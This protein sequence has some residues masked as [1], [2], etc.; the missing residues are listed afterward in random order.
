V[1]T[2]TADPNAA[3]NT[4]SAFTAVINPVP[5]ISGA[6]VDKSTLWP[7]NH[8]MVDVEVMYAVTGA[9]ATATTTLSIAS[10]EGDDADYQVVDAHHVRVRAERAGGDNDR[11][12]TI[13][14]AATSD[15]KTFTRRTVTVT[16]PH[17]QGKGK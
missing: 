15:K 17:D 4:A 13:T 14:I 1:Q 7:P 11:V 5:T 10:N 3:N 2:A 16:V 9:C 8:K 6:G 12:Y